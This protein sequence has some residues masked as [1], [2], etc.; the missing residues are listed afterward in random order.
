MPKSSTK[1]KDISFC[2]MDKLRKMQTKKINHEPASEH[3]SFS[4]LE[5][6]EESPKAKKAGVI[7]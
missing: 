6:Y 2:Y 7:E 5:I 4:S 3:D 1:P